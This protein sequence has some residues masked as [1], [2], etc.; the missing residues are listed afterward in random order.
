MLGMEGRA[1]RAPRKV[2]C[3]GWWTMHRV[4]PTNY[5]Y[6]PSRSHAT[7]TQNADYVGVLEEAAGLL[8][9]AECHQLYVLVMLFSPRNPGNI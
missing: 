5:G 1:R 8:D 9:H 7:H 6:L 4:F 2:R 3:L